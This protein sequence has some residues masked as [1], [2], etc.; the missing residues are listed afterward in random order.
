MGI[1]GIGKTSVY[2]SAYNQKGFP[3]LRSRNSI[4]KHC[5]DLFFFFQ[6]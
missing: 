4:R 1:K 6:N 5:V 2:V 3:Q